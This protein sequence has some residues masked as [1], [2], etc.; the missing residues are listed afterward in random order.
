MKTT[1]HTALTISGLGVTAAIGQGK[2]A[3]SS[4]LLE[5]RHAFAVMQRP[6]RQKESAFLGAEIADLV[7]PDALSKR[8][9]RSASFSAQVALA[10]LHEAWHDAALDGCDPT[11][12]GLVV[13]GSNV[14]QRELVQTWESYAARPLF[15]RPSYAFSFMD[16]DLCGLATEQFGIRGLAH[17]AGGASASG[18]LAIL[19]AIQAVESGQVDV[20]IALG[21]L[22]DLSYLE[23]HAFRALGAMG[24][25]RFANEPAEA[26]RPFDRRR[27]GFIF[28]EC[29]GAVVV[30]RE[31]AVREGAK[32][33]ARLAGWGT[34]MDG[35]RNPDPSLE[36]E[37]A[38]IRKALAQAGWSAADVDYVNPHGTGSPLGDEIELQ[39]LRECG[40]SHAY[41]NATKSIVGHGL[42]AAGT[43][44]VIATLLQM[45]AGML[46]PTR[47]LTDPIDPDFRWVR[48]QSV[49]H[50]IR[51]ALNLSLG[52]G[53]INT[54]LCLARP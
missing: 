14:Q 35:H 32:R 26:A 5:G 23:C 2:A 13:G 38:V 48:Q 52:F 6:G 36:G 53:G 40:L 34:V 19:Q 41:L 12:I 46:H 45:E 3:F 50:P 7:Q 8:V 31:G 33:Y 10:T 43:V 24:S 47:N 21:A 1:T 27:D 11:R 16:S 17:T 15:L 28:G 54:A 9:L 4:A 42:T 30:E 25:D 39:A 22:M 51:N 37:I 49:V 29:C 20:C 44:E 18:H